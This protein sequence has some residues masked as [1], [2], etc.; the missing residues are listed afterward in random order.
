M[1][2]AYKIQVDK[3]GANVTAQFDVRV[4][5][6]GS[7]ELLADFHLN[8]EGEN[9]VPDF[10][11][12]QKQFNGTRNYVLKKPDKDAPVTFDISTNQGWT[13]SDSCTLRGEKTRDQCLFANE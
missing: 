2:V 1:A 8:V 4:K 11:P 6:M 13:K 5:E 12:G 3:D 9:L 7:P 10:K